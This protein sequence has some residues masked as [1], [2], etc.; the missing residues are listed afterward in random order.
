[1]TIEELVEPKHPYYG[2][3]LNGETYADFKSFYDV[4]LRKSSARNQT[5]EGIFFHFNLY[6]FLVL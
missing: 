2:T 3:G 1:M 5:F 6:G 4:C